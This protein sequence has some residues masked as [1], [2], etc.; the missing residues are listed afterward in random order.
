MKQ[1]LKV[2]KRNIQSMREIY[3][4][5]RWVGNGNYYVYIF[6]YTL[7]FIKCYIKKII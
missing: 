1:I 5:G 7:K 2:Y 4:D 3:N 6:R